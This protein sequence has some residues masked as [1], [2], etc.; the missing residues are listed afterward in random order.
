MGSKEHNKKV[1]ISLNEFWMLSICKRKRSLLCVD[2]NLCDKNKTKSFRTFVIGNKIKFS[3][4]II[5]T[6]LIN[7]D[8]QQ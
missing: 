5:E 8:K 3:L 4:I 2:I 7:N 1:L 6:S